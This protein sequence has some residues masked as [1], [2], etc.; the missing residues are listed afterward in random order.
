MRP[1]GHA[2]QAPNQPPGAQAMRPSTA[3]QAVPMGHA[4]P[5]E[6]DSAHWLKKHPKPAL[7][8]KEHAASELHS[9]E[10]IPANGL[11]REQMPLAH[12]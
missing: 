1:A 2:T 8:P 9:T 11:A 12:P 5:L 7:P 4:S 6:Q 10:Q 3:M